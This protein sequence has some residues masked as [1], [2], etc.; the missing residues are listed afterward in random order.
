M[1]QPKGQAGR[2]EQAERADGEFETGVCGGLAVALV[3]VNGAAASPGGGAARGQRVLLRRAV[4]PTRRLPLAA[5]EVAQG[6][7]GSDRLGYMV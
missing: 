4:E 1:R 7:D 2:D 6:G 3:Q 5:L